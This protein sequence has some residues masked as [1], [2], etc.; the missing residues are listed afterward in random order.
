MGCLLTLPGLPN[1]HSSRFSTGH[2]RGQ[3]TR[4]REQVQGLKG[5]EVPGHIAELQG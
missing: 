5:C 1:A 4:R 2:L 3:R